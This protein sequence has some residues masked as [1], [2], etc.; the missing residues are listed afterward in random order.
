MH[1]LSAIPASSTT[2]ATTTPLTVPAPPA[3]AG[4]HDLAALRDEFERQGFVILRGAHPP[5]WVEHM[6]ALYPSLRARQHAPDGNPPPA[7]DEL[8]ELEPQAT[9]AAIARPEVLAVAEA[10]MGPL[11]QL[12]SVTY[13]G[14]APDAATRADAQPRVAGWHRDL[15]AAFPPADG[16]YVP[17]L[18]FNAMIYLQDLSDENGPLRVIPGS[19]RRA[20][21]I[22]PAQLALPHPEEL[23]LYPKAG[24]AVLFHHAL[25]H[26]GTPNR[27]L[28]TR[29]FF[30]VTY[31]HCWLK[32]RGT[33]TGP[34]C[35][36]LIEQARAA[37]DRRLL[38]LLAAD[39]KAITRALYNHVLEPERVVWERWQA[40]DRAEAS[41]VAAAHV[42]AG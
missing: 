37:G 42:P 21:T 19:H 10:L 18:L 17:P 1:L 8:L 35:R 31:N 3:A 20:M 34:A 15:F 4:A 7:F 26:T 36:A 2:T 41:A 12:E 13:A 32:H 27:S 9:I 38:R 5:A 11:L 14:F 22:A 25:L 39:D 6:R 40:E 29:Y 23:V 28:E 24:D 16:H 30:C 33:Y